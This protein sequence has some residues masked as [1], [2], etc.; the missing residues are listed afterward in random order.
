MMDVLQQTNRHLS[1]LSRSTEAV[2]HVNIPPGQIVQSFPWRRSN[3]EDGRPLSRIRSHD[4]PTSGHQ[5]HHAFDSVEINLWD[6]G[7]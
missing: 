6:Q 1:V 7:C 3:K 5:S 2:I 4:I